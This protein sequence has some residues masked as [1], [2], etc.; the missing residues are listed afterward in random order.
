MP[1]GLGCVGDSKPEL[2]A[3]SFLGQGFAVTAE[4]ILQLFDSLPRSCSNR[5]PQGECFG[6]GAFVRVGVGLR[7]SCKQ[8][9]NSIS[10]INKFAQGIVDS[11][12]YTSFVI[13]D[14]NQAE[15]RRDTQNARLPDVVIPLSKFQG[16]EIVVR[17]DQREVALDVAR[18][19]VS[20]CAR[21]YEHYT[22]PFQGRRVVL[23][24]FSLKGSKHLSE[25]EK[26]CLCN[27]GFPLPSEADLDSE[28]I[29]EP[30]S[31]RTRASKD[32][33]PSAS[34]GCNSLMPQG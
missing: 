24:L 34:L 14:N 3:K 27:L 15:S 6:A 33:E 20:F 10:A 29:P 4:Q 28:E 7:Q 5:S 22:R 9:P 19:P 17:V 2:L 26:Q 25:E 13:L 8:Y 1:A 12:Y 30:R 23:V 31:L 11:L 16:G 32:A 18:G 21:Q